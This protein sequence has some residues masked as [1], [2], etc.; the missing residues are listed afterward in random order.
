L[1]CT[2]NYT[3]DFLWISNGIAVFW[4]RND[5]SEMGVAGELLNG[6]ATEGMSKERLGKEYDQG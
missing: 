6:G 3:V 5:P 4:V 1:A 2:E